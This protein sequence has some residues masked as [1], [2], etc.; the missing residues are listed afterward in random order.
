MTGFVLDAPPA[1]RPRL[2]SLPPFHHSSAE[3]GFDFLDM[4]GMPL[5]DWQR[6]SL[7]ATLGETEAGLWA[8]PWVVELCPRQNGKS[9][10]WAARV[11]MGLFVFGERL[12]TYTA[13]TVKTALEVFRLV[14]FYALR[15]ASTRRLVAHVIHT[16]GREEIELYSGQRFM[17]Q[18]RVRNSGRGFSGDLLIMDEAMDL[19]DQAPINA[20]IPT[21]AARPNPQLVFTS[22][23]GDPG[24]VVLA[25]LRAQ[26]QRG[27]EGLAYLEYSADERAASDDPIAWAQGNPALGSLISE[28]TVRRERAIMSDDGFRQERL[29]IWATQVAGAVISQAAWDHARAEVNIEPIPGLLG[30][31]YD[32]SPDRSWASVMVA[33]GVGEKV[34]VRTARHRLGDGWLVHDLSTLA[35]GYQVPVT[36]DASGPGRDVAEQLRVGGTEV[37][38]ISGRDYSAAC[39]RLLSGIV[40]QTI[41]HHPDLALDEAA[42]IATTRKYG[43]SW[44]FARTSAGHGAATPISPLTAAAIAVWANDHAGT[45]VPA[46]R[47][48]V[49]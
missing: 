42:A 13:Q 10:K 21:L 49:F 24:S 15:H 27:Q 17:V 11:L 14:E 31:A 4:L 26:G 16:Q 34:H 19:R 30:L 18:S 20:L 39:Q 7:A 8:A 9:Y 38:A 41:T 3:E 43:E 46:P 1:A 5:L 36:Y 33:Y 22:S 29:G 40:N 47:P 45:D 35:E 6:Y 37:V 32:V 2:E 48:E 44:I 23:A 25:D 28:D 12:I